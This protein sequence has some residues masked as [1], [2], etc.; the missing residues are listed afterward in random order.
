M[1]PVHLV[2]QIFVVTVPEVVLSH[3]HQPGNRKQSVCSNRAD[4][5]LAGPA[6][7]EKVT[8]PFVINRSEKF[9]VGS[10]HAR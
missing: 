5:F 4:Q 6:A 9:L 1:G 2:D 8:G 7:I 10:Q 3:P